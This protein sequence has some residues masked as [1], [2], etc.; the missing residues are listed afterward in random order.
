MVSSDR[1]VSN[2]GFQRR[3]REL[4]KDD[5]KEGCRLVT[6]VG[7]S[8]LSIVGRDLSGTGK[9]VGRQLLR[10]EEGGFA[11]C[12]RDFLIFIIYILQN[13]VVLMPKTSKCRCFDAV[14]KKLNLIESADSDGTDWFV[15]FTGWNIGS[16]GLTS[17]QCNYGPIDQ[18]ELEP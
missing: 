12:N 15:W 4:G 7:E 8:Y 3:D 2:V 16:S 5:D 6:T 11:V 17:V 18:T 1:E 14:K 10:G 13:D 9:V